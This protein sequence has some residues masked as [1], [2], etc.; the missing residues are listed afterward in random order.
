MDQRIGWGFQEGAHYYAVW[1]KGDSLIFQVDTKAFLIPDGIRCSNIRIDS[2]REFILSRDEE[3]VFN[4]KYKGV[5]EKDPTFDQ[6][7]LETTDFFFWVSMVWNDSSMRQS[8]TSH[9]IRRVRGL[10]ENN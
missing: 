2:G 1:L 8:L 9:W 6:L 7:D 4:L 3:I 5:S 10:K